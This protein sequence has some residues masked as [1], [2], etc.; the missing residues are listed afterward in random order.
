MT[1]TKTAGQKMTASVAKFHSI[2]GKTR[3]RRRRHI[4]VR[5]QI[6]D[7]I[8]YAATLPG[9]FT[10]EQH[11]NMRVAYTAVNGYKNHILGGRVDS[12]IC[13]YVREGMSPYQFLKLIA[14]MVDAGVANAYEAEQFFRTL[15]AEA[16]A[17]YAA[18]Y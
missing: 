4:S 9:Y 16:N 7:T 1:A 13:W 18:K 12:I 2:G 15:Y 17:A 11:D 8:T 6:A 3:N 5:E 10:P 14:R